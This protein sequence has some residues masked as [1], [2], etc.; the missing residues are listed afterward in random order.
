MLKLTIT[1]FLKRLTLQIWRQSYEVTLR[2]IRWFLLLSFVAIFLSNL[3]ECHHFTHYWQVKPDPGPS[4]RQGYA[5]LLTTAICNI[6]TDLLLVIFPIPII[7][8]SAMPL[9]RKFSLICLFALS[10]I[11]IAVTFYQIPE[12]IKNRSRQQ[13]RT[14]WA[15]IE[16]LAATAVAN[17]LVLGSFVRDRGVKKQKWKVRSTGESLERSISLRGTVARAWGSDEDL[18][19]DLGLGV[20]R[21]LRHH[22]HIT[23][24]PRP[25]PMATSG[26][27]NIRYARGLSL[28][29]TLSTLSGNKARSL[30]NRDWDFA[31]DRNENAYANGGENSEGRDTSS[32]D[33]DLL[34]IRQH[35]SHDDDNDSDLPSMITPRKVSF[36]DVGGLLES[37]EPNKNDNP[38]R[39]NNTTDATISSTLSTLTHDLKS[40]S[41]PFLQ[42]QQSHSHPSQPQVFPHPTALSPT[43]QLQSSNSGVS[44]SNMIRNDRRGSAALL[45]DLGGL[46]TPLTPSTSPAT[47]DSHRHSN[48]DA[49][50]AIGSA[51][52]HT[53]ISSYSPS[54]PNPNPN[55]RPPLPASRSEIPAWRQSFTSGGRS[56]FSSDPSDPSNHFTH[57]AIQ[58]APIRSDRSAS[59]SNNQ[60]LNDVG[61]LLS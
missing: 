56:H 10:I 57:D 17:A 40:L 27:D 19:R 51:P 58:M 7:L 53:H 48:P 32:E 29:R 45:Q 59:A 22:R 55:A 38:Q 35:R 21:E 20:D 39:A 4:C 44:P 6:L 36:F 28:T 25:A 60:I 9:R 12:I 52:S 24:I 61:G 46:I 5:Q 31:T 11:P 37:D 54:I 26:N 49:N 15:S 13:T 42:R 41:N 1:E 2:C 47:A 14:L 23:N 34:K 18:V 50:N 43:P 30:T 33:Y 8:S 16:I 3:L